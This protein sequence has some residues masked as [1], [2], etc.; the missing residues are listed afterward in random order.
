MLSI[1]DTRGYELAPL[2]YKGT[3]VTGHQ[4]FSIGDVIRK[5]REA[6][7][8]NQTRLGQEAARFLIR[9]S[10]AA[11]DKSTVSKVERDPYTSE[12]GT[13]WRLLAAVGLTF[14]DVESRV[15]SPVKALP[16]EPRPGRQ[17]AR[18]ESTGS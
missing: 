11:I 16:D 13:V 7:R 1:D 10:D 8:W 14:A 5:A 4:E 17:T 2:R 15:S 18:R 3:A 6:R 9:E 12:L